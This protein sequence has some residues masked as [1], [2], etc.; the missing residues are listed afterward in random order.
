MYGTCDLPPYALNPCRMGVPGI[1]TYSRTA[2][3][4]EVPYVL[5]EPKAYGDMPYVDRR[6]HDA[7]YGPL[8]NHE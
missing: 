4:G 2:V 7:L 3:Y 6:I 1:M 8:S 5:P